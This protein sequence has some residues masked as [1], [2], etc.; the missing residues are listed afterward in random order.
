MGNDVLVKARGTSE[1]F[2][3]SGEKEGEGGRGE[4]GKAGGG[5][6]EIAALQR[7]GCGGSSEV[8]KTDKRPGIRLLLVSARPQNT[9]G[10]GGGS[11]L[12]RAHESLPS[13]A[14]AQPFTD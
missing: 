7:V 3:R 6:G 4:A 10:R 12:M 9:D 11:T 2:N 8:K 14:P 5:G 1:L 13:P